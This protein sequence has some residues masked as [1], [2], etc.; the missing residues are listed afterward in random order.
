MTTDNAIV[1]LT[2]RTPALRHLMECLRDYPSLYVNRMEVFEHWFL[3]NGNGYEW[4]RGKLS[5]GRFDH[6]QKEQRMSA[7]DACMRMTDGLCGIYPF[8]DNPR[9]ALIHEAQKATGGYRECAEHFVARL[10]SWKPNDYAAACRIQGWKDVGR[11]VRSL[12]QWQAHFRKMWPTAK[13]Q[14]P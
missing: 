12:R 14:L 6:E 7:S 11:Y 5:I 9:Y 10:L 4:R 3:V 13:L 1:A 2:C 8:T